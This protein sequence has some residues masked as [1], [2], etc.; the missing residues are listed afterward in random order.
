MREC[1]DE[2]E[3]GSLKTSLTYETSKLY[4]VWDGLMPRAQSEAQWFFSCPLKCH[5]EWKGKSRSHSASRGDVIFWKPRNVPQFGCL[6]IKIKCWKVELELLLLTYFNL[7]RVP[8]IIKTITLWAFLGS[9]YFSTGTTT[10]RFHFLV[11]PTVS[12]ALRW[13][14]G[15]RLRNLMKEGSLWR[16]GGC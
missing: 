16:V 1:H 11:N 14:H 5:C 7:W 8:I 4:C 6:N 10:T 3:T 2:W 9:N 13:R 12:E 15:R